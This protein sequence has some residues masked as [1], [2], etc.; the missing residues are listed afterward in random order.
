MRP[1]AKLR[2]PILACVLLLIAGFVLALARIGGDTNVALARSGCTAI[3]DSTYGFFTAR[4]AIDGKWMGQ[5]EYGALD[6]WHASLEKPHP[7]WIWLRFRQ[8]AR[9]C[10]VVIHCVDFR[11]YPVDSVGEYSADG[12]LTFRTL[13]TI[14]NNRMKTSQLT[15]ERGFTPVTT[16]NFRL[17]I[18]RSSDA[19]RPGHAQVSEIEVF[20]RFVGRRPSLPAPKLHHFALLLQPTSTRGMTVTRRAGE[21]E[22][23]SP[24]LRVGLSTKQPRINA[25]CWDSLGKGKVGANLLGDARF[26]P[27]PLFAQSGARTSAVVVGNVARYDTLLPGGVQAHW[28]VRVSE[29]GFEV[30]AA[31][32]VENTFMCNTAAWPEFA[33]D[34]SKTPVAPLASPRPGAAAPLPCLIHAADYG[35]LLLQSPNPNAQLQSESIRMDNRWNVSVATEARRTAD[36]LNVLRSG[37]RRVSFMAT[38]IS[39]A[40]T[41]P[42]PRLAS[43]PRWWLNTFQYRPDIGILSNNIVSDNCLFCIHE[44]ADSAVFT[45]GLPGGIDAIDLVRESVDRYLHGARG[46]G[47]GREDI[48]VDIYP[49][50][51]IAAWD[52]VRVTGDK[53]LLRKWLPH[54]ERLAE[55][56]QKQDRNCNGLPESTRSGVSG[57]IE[58]P[59][60]NWWDQINFGHE[61][62]YACALAYRAFLC[63]SDLENLA[64][65]SSGGDSEIP[66][67]LCE[68]PTQLCEIPTQLCGNAGRSSEY[69]RRAGRIRAA[70]VPA[71]YN[72]ATGVIAGW[73]D[74]RGRLHD[75]YFTFV[76]GIAIAYGLV[77]EPL[78]NR[79]VDRIEAKMRQVGYSR[80]DLG[81]PGPLI[82]I[83]E[84]DYGYEAAGSGSDGW[85]TFENGG[86]T[87]CFASY[88]IQALYK[89]GRRAEADRILW[90]MV[91][92]Y[93]EGRYQNG[94]GK[95]GEWTRWDGK[96]SGYEGMLADAYCTQTVLFTGYYGI[97]FGPQG[98][99]LEPWSPL[100]GKHVPLGQRYMGRSVK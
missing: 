41:S 21:V 33:F 86:A 4:C 63:L 44:Y 50:L 25:L 79:I 69:A 15:I 19:E 89:L 22:F 95:G 6:R 35:T 13:F 55:A 31:R 32:Y 45:P 80:F 38:V 10:R 58:S 76:N 51:L 26:A 91:K 30:A 57:K 71:F 83:P 1:V 64:C 20:G 9:I 18:L 5:E 93:G 98:F 61:D 28:E 68:I 82:P 66:T 96:P 36:C 23:R 67:Q 49:S 62:A 90:P 65:G 73:R 100:K 81:L 60:S 42:D 43:L 99:H 88:Y 24:W 87:A 53:A 14:R 12:G 16:D 29:K 52:V 2:Y 92:S 78:A 27:R 34:V 8:P 39:A 40:P 75:Y 48:M 84:N 70:Y 85:Q 54:L 74:S 72:P 94:V 3:A 37:E 47:K 59:T 97:G 46:Y 7:H 77:P 17:R 56:M 11:S